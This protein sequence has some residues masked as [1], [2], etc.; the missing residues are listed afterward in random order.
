MKLSWKIPAATVYLVICAS[1]ISGRATGDS[2]DK[3]KTAVDVV[4]EPLMQ[5]YRIPGMAVGFIDAENHYEFNFGV[6]SVATKKP[7]ADGTLFEVGSISKTLT[8]TLAAYAQAKGYLSLSD[9]VGKHVAALEGTPFGSVTLLE[10]G[11]H[12]PGGLPLQVPDDVHNEDELMQY[13]KNWK[14]SCP[15]GTCRTYSNPSIGMLGFITA[16]AMRQ[17]FDALIETQLLPA[18]G[19]KN[20]YINMPA[21]RMGDYAQG[22]KTDGTPIRVTPGVLGSEAYGIKTTA[23]DLMRFLDDCMNTIKGNGDLQRAISDVRT[24]YFKAGTMTQDLIWEQYPYP[25]ELE[26]LV[27]GN[28]RAVSNDSLPASAIEPPEKPRS[29]VWINKTGS[30]NGFGAYVAFIPEKRIGIVMLANKSYPIEAR[31]TAAYRILTSLASGEEE[32]KEH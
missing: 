31:V 17:N 7:V 6:A 24:G 3:V 25:L 26:A 29:N 18:L 32:K 14:P 22:Y 15:P 11:T 28:S 1:A 12:T 4:I 30:T 19:L 21:D 13:F 8:A 23:T 5:E 27:D 2:R 10:L 16:K 9:T 20:T